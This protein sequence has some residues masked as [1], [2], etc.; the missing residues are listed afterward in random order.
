MAPSPEASST[1]TDVDRKILFRGGAL[2]AL[3]SRD[4]RLLWVGAFV[5][6]TGTWIH[7]T[8]LLWFVKVLTDSNTWVSVINLANF[9]PVLLL[10][11]FSGSLADRMD[12]K[13]LILLTQ[14]LMMLGAIA[15]GVLTTL[16]IVSLGAMIALTLLMGAAFAF[17]FPA[18]RAIIPDLVPRKDILNGVA[19]DAAQFNLA[20]F[21]GPALGSLILAVFGVATAF[22]INAASF[23]A[24]IAAVL[25]IR[26][27]TPGSPT[28]RSGT[29]LHIGEGLRYVKRQR[30]AIN[31]LAVLAFTSFFG[32]PFIV[33]LPSLS[34]DVL[35]KG[36]TGYGLLLGFTGLG[37]AL[38]APL[39][40][41]INRH[42]SE[43]WIIRLSATIASMF[44]LVISFSRILWLSLLLS[45]GLGAT[46]LMISA[47]I[48]TVLQSRVERDMRGRIMSFYILVLQGIFPLGGIVMGYLSD[49]WSTPTTLLLEGSACLCLSLA[50]LLFPSILRDAVSVT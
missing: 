48:N 7:N 27:S 31:L 46:Y 26:T 21:A 18:W 1:A 4:F 9:L 5:S 23:L 17:T 45:I 25:F 14:V 30:W 15:L 38:A 39:V 24:V 33:L 41:L 49:L 34:R 16:G 3:A 42:I 13:R 22:Y 47:S 50:L 40:T 44:L 2:S 20:R 37:A 32:M 28:P 35:G 43:K 6:N 19:L 36:S 12:R 10:V 8:A 29:M 11:L